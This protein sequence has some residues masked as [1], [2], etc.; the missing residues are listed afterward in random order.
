METKQ[1]LGE[2]AKQSLWQFHNAMETNTEF[3]ICQG[4]LDQKSIRDLQVGPLEDYI[5]GMKVSQS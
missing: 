5:L 2:K 4:G 3:R 1:K